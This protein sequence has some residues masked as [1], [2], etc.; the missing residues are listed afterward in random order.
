[1]IKSKSSIP[2]IVE[3]KIKM[4]M[5]RLDEWREENADLINSQEE[6]N[7]RSDAFIELYKSKRQEYLELNAQLQSI[8]TQRLK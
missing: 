7:S 3:I 5:K 2:D 1:M 6:L 8:L 4:K